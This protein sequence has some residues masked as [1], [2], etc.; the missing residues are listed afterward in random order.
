VIPNTHDDLLCATLST[1]ADRGGRRAYPFALTFLP[2]GESF[3]NTNVWISSRPADILQSEHV[4]A[5]SCQ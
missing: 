3:V 5:N 4:F 2:N 1:N